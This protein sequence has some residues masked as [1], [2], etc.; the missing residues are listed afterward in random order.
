VKQLRNGD[1]AGIPY[2]LD[3]RLPCIDLALSE[4]PCLAGV[5]LGAFVVRDNALRK[6]DPDPLDTSVKVK[7]E[8]LKVKGTRHH[9][10]IFYRLA[11]G[12]SIALSAKMEEKSGA[13]LAALPR[14]R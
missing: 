10:I 5:T 1:G 9:K 2:G 4:K 3:D 13:G 7:G 12:R 11:D 6:N 14:R 8:R